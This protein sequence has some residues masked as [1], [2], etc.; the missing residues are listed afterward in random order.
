M[1]ALAMQWVKYIVLK[2]DTKVCSFTIRKFHGRLAGEEL[3][4]RAR[5]SGAYPLF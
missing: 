2:F 1:L 4:E 5:V 3:E